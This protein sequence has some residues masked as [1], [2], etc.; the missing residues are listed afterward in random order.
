MA[1]QEDIIEK[2]IEYK[3]IDV[4]AKINQQGQPEFF[5]SLSSGVDF[6]ISILQLHYC[7]CK[8]Y[9]LPSSIFHLHTTK[10]YALIYVVYSTGNY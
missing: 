2:D 5:F 6:T 8:S 3:Q 10:S 7:F 4:N 9:N 1:G